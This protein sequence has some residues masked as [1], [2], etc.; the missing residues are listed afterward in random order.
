VE[1]GLPVFPAD[2][3]SAQK[4][5]AQFFHDYFYVGRYR[6]LNAQRYSI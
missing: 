6:I 2:A 3:G 1:D 5:D 4:S